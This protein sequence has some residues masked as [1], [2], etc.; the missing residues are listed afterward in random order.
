MFPKKGL[1]SPDIFLLSAISQWNSCEQSIDFSYILSRLVRLM[2]LILVYIFSEIKGKVQSIAIASLN[3]RKHYN[4][5]IPCEALP[6]ARWNQVVNP[7]V[8]FSWWNEICREKF[9]SIRPNQCGVYL[10]IFYIYTSW[11]DGVLNWGDI[12]T[13]SLFTQKRG[14]LSLL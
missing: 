7:F 14:I 9:Y 6:K 5:Y 13:T 1:V 10:K 3:R 4:F 12:Y 2:V 11:L 8:L